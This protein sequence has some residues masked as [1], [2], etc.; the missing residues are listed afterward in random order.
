[1]ATI[2]GRG[3]QKHLMTAKCQEPKLIRSRVSK[4]TPSRPGLAS[5][6]VVP[7]RSLILIARGREKRALFLGQE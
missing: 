7:K 2:E 1:M 5:Q 6:Y 3:K 4:T